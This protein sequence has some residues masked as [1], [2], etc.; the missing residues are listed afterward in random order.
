MN[1]PTGCAGRS[2][3]LTTSISPSHRRSLDHALGAREVEA[4][5]RTVGPY[6]E[7]WTVMKDPEDNGFCVQ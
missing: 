7:R 4:K 1:W 3:V 5:T 2:V 6:T